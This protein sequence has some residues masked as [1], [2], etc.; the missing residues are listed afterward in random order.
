MLDEEA[1]KDL[2]RGLRGHAVYLPCVIAA[3]TG[4]RRG[5]ILALR[6]SE[7]DLGRSVLS[8]VRSLRICMYSPSSWKVGHRFRGASNLF[9]GVEFLH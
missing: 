7:V 9:L 1:T 8:V 2:L 6:W 5:E 3:G 4:M